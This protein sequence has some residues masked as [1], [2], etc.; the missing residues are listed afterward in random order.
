MRLMASA[1]VRCK[2]DL[3]LVGKRVAIIG[4]SRGIGRAIVEGFLQEGAQV[5]A[6]AR[7]QTDLDT[8][9][10]SRGCRALMADLSNEAGA[11]ALH[12]AV[13][14]AFGELD[15]L[16]CNVGS[17]RSVPPGEETAPEWRRMLDINLFPAVFAL[18]A[19][20]DLLAEGGAVVCISSIAGRRV[21]GAPVAYAAA[22]AALDALIA[23]SARPLSDRGVRIVGVAPGNI[24]FPGSVW[25]RK[26]VEDKDGVDV[27]L[28]RDVALK[29]LGKP[30]EIAD[31]VVFLASERASFITGTVVTA[32]GG[33][34]GIA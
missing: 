23:N 24:L 32:D 9:A 18:D 27:M 33:Q 7:S 25:D 20:R 1:R 16:V 29:R 13:N 11:A 3:R 30:Q 22:K 17:G 6:I 26:T 14:D 31:L 21:L 8:L 4:G 15:V 28:R 19:C 12:R 2:M 5:L 34:A 10:Q